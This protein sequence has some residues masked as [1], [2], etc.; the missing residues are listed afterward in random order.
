PEPMAEIHSDTAIKY[1]V[2]DGDTIAVETKRGQIKIKVR[3]T[4]DLAPGVIGIP[5]GWAQ[6][7]ANV[8]TELEPRDPVTG[9]TEFK[10]LLCRVRKLE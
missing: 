3:T 5:H 2:A 6:A 8:L 7:N 4:E 1:G 10:A 9:Y